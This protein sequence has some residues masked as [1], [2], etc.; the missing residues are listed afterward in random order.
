MDSLM[1]TRRLYRCAVFTDAFKMTGKLEPTGEILTALGDKQRTC[2]PIHDVEITP[3]SAYSPLG[4]LAIPELII[5]KANVTMVAVLDAAD[6]DDIRLQASIT[7]LTVY[8]PAFAIQAEFHL[9]GELRTR[10]FIDGLAY[11][12]LPATNAKLFPLLPSKLGPTDNL[13]FVILNKN[14]ITM[15]HE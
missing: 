14:A 4:P 15:Y 7:V 5:N 13:P 1:F 10:D 11:D 6:Y 2:I 12:F 8:T 9:G 3:I